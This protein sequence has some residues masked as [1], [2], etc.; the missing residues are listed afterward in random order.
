MGSDRMKR[1]V[2]ILVAIVFWGLVWQVSYMAL[3]KDILLSSP[4]QVVT[5]LIQ[6]ST[7][8]SF[9]ISAGL[10]LFR[11]LLFFRSSPGAVG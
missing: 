4:A 1:P 6:L 10:S 8:K 7:L 11:I 2:K 3:N 9:W 5:R